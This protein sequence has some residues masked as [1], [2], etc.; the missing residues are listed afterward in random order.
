MVASK[1]S[2]ADIVAQ[3][4]TM[5]TAL[6]ANM[7]QVERR[8]IDPAFIDGFIDA[9][10][11]LVEANIEQEKM[12]AALKL[13]TEEVSK[14]RE[15]LNNYMKEIKRVVKLAIPQAQW[16]EFGITD[17]QW[18]HAEDLKKAAATHWLPLF[19]LS[20]LARLTFLLAEELRLGSAYL[21]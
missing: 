7:P 3:A 19:Y 20:R 11:K 16:I 1:R 6:K 13:K 8:W 10:R 2:F 4:D 17:K 12:K 15:N 9:R 5:A 21:S 18:Y 14:Y